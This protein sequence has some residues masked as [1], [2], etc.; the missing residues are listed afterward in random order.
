MEE[1][2][3]EF[4]NVFS[5]YLISSGYFLCPKMLMTLKGAGTRGGHNHRNK[6]CEEQYK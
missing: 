2:K 6:K 3:Q 1:K 4:E 5:C